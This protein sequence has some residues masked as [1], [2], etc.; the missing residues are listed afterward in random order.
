MSRARRR[1]KRRERRRERKKDE[2]KCL[3]SRG[4][5]MNERGKDEDEFE[6]ADKS[7]DSRETVSIEE[8]SMEFDVTCWNKR[9]EGKEDER[10]RKMR[11]NV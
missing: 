8:C 9:R 7:F 1:E 10:E 5:D 4:R 3:N 6:L 2:G 11:E